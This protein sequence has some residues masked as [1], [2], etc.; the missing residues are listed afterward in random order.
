MSAV[1]PGGVEAFLPI[2]ALMGLKRFVFSG[3]YDMI[4]PAGLT[5]LIVFLLISIIFKR[6]FCGYICPIGLISETIGS[7]GRNIKIHRFIAYPLSSLKYLLLGFFVYII[8]IQ[9]SLPAIEG[10]LNAP[11]NKVSDAKMMR[12]FTEPSRTTLMVLAVLLILGLLFRN[13]WCRFLCPY[14]ALMGL[15]SLVSPFKIKREKD[16]CVNCMKCTNICPMDIQVHKAGTVHSPECIGCHDC[17]RVRAND[18][19]LKTYKSDY[20]S[21]TLAVF[22]VFWISIAAATLTGFWRSEVS[23]GEYLFWLER[24]GQLSH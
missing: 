17:V 14:G 8:L 15:V 21:L 19:C 9:M 10:F 6:G 13:F 2:S 7:A 16:A 4:H 5:L 12:F 22:A 24:L 20:R 23:S 11:Y 18:E 1:K 3:N